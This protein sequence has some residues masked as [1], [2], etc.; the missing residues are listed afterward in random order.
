MLFL[1]LWSFVCYI[2]NNTLLVT[3]W[4]SISEY[5]IELAERRFLWCSMIKRD[6]RLEHRNLVFAYNIIVTCYISHQTLNSRLN[7]MPVHNITQSCMNHA[8]C[9]L[10]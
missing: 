8:A 1:V 9:T 2:R 3:S 5:S 4:Y 6:E 7:F 10:K